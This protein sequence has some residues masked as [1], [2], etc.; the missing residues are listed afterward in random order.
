V[1]ADRAALGRRRRER[2]RAAL[3][4]AAMKVIAR[5]GPDAPTIENFIEESGFARGTFYN[6][7]ETREEL[8]VAVGSAVSEQLLDSMQALRGLADPA[9]RVSCSVR[10]FVRM[11]A[12]DPTWGAV[13]VRIALLAAPIGPSMRD[14]MVADIMDGLSSGRFRSPSVQ[15]AADLVLGLGMMGMRSV[16]RR[17]AGPK[18]AEDVAELVLTALGVPDAAEIARRPMDEATL[19]ARS[20]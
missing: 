15:A 7:F 6:Y 2:T 20:K 4:N 16:L 17:D 3:V 10:A 14:Y 13:I 11:A 8:L 19:A 12:S 5:L 1:A 18:H 9:D